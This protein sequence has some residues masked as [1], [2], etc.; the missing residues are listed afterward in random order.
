MSK[1][2]TPN[3]IKDVV[4]IETG[5]KT[6]AFK[7]VLRNDNLI[8]YAGTLV[9]GKSNNGKKKEYFQL[10]L[11]LEEHLKEEIDKCPSSRN[12]TINALLAYAI[13]DLKEKGKTL[14]I[15]E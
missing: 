11:R 4:N 10:L 14:V 1:K 5:L 6:E 3:W 7:P 15:N 2:D 12:S 9:T 8:D 13:A